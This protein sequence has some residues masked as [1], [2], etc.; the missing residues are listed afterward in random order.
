M[1]EHLATLAHLHDELL[2]A[3]NSGDADLVVELVA[4]REAAIDALKQKFIAADPA[5]REAVQPELAALMPLDR[6]LQ[7]RAG[8]L[9]GHLRSRLDEQKSSTP[10]RERA[11]VTGIFDRQA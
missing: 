4:R 1:H 5:A 11:V 9:L 3:L 6:D 7:T 2:S 10:R 8:A